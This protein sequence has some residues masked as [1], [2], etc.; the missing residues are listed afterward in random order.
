MI[1]SDRQAASTTRIEVSKLLSDVTKISD[2]MDS[3]NTAIH[4]RFTVLEQDSTAKASA[5]AEFSK[6]ITEAY[7]KVS[8]E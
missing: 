7:R 5:I 3:N 8:E 1:T 2:Y 4:D 6:T